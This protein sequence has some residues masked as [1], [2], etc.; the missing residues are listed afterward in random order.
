[1][2][3][4]HNLRDLMNL[5]WQSYTGSLIHAIIHPILQLTNNNR[6]HSLQEKKKKTHIIIMHHSLHILIV[7]IT[8]MLASRDLQ[9]LLARKCTNRKSILT[10]KRF[11]TRRF[12][13]GNIKPQEIVG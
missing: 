13:A 3:K 2:K 7:K 1:M 9:M 11:T 6:H 5:V 4:N 8:D 12:P 10:K